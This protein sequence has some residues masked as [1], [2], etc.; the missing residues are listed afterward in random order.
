M[1]T[2]KF[3]IKQQVRIKTSEGT[4]R[5]PPND[6]KGVIGTIAEQHIADWLQS[7]EIVPMEPPRSYYVEIAENHTILVGEDWLEP[8]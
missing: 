7:S 1:Q 5:E 4:Y 2:R 3:A 8:V 6:A